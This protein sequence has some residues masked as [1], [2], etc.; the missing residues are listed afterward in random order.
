[1]TSV[2]IP[3]NT[4]GVFAFSMLQVNPFEFAPYAIL[5]W[6]TPILAIIMALL[7]FKITYAKKSQP[8]TV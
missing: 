3:W 2:L 6:T 8:T 1:M 5:N 4:C 7:G